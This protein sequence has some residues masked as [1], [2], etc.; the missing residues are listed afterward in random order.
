MTSHESDLGK[1]GRENL[2]RNLDNDFDSRAKEISWL[3]DNLP[4][5][6]FRAS[7]KLSWGM[8]YISTNVEKLT[9]YS[10]MDFT[11]QKLSW[12]DIVFPE[13]VTIIDKAVKKAKKNKSSYQ[14]E[15]RIKKLDGSTAFIQ[16]QAH[17]IYDDG[18]KLA[19]IAGVFLDLTLEEKRKKDSRD[20]NTEDEKIQLEMRRN[21]RRLRYTA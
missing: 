12:S 5:T 6:V 3:V 14:I 1:I 19:Y 16:E 15:Y 4:V 18:G 9:G 13:D 20:L 11:D 7:S 17:L 21:K 2:L 10:K 8:D